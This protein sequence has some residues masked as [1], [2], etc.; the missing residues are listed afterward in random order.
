MPGGPPRQ[1]NTKYARPL[2]SGRGG[3]TG[4]LEWRRRGRRLE[5]DGAGSGARAR[6]DARRSYLYAYLDQAPA[7]D[8]SF[9]CRAGCT[10]SKRNIDVNPACQRRGVASALYDTVRAEHPDVLVDHGARW[11]DGERWWLAYCCQR[12]L[13][14]AF[15]AATSAAAPRRLGGG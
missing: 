6:A 15:Q 1:F 7:S 8:L 14:P 12:G 3:E 5:R 9:W 10:A 13:D 2:A 4:A 11:P